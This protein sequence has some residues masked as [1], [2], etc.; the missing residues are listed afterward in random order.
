V[1]S[2]LGSGLGSSGCG[3]AKKLGG[4]GGGGGGGGSIDGSNL[5]SNAHELKSHDGS[6]DALGK[7]GALSSSS[8]SIERLRA[9]LVLHSEEK[10]NSR[11]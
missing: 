10:Q 2:G 11:Q 8:S 4:G 9:C 6:N 7:G 3:A 1:G 5:G